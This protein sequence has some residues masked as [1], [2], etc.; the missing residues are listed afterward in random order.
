V[1]ERTADGDD[2]APAER[3]SPLEAI[4]MYTSNAAYAAF[5]ERSNGT[6]EPGKLAD[7]VV[8]GDNPLTVTPEAIASI[9]V[10]AT[11]VGGRF[12]FERP[13]AT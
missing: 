8:L 7:L 2:Y 11:I 3:L 12:A 1:T 6:I 13:M 9:P 10:V 5:D 4:R